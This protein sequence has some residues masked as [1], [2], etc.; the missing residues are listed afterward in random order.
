M[1]PSRFDAAESISADSIEENLRITEKKRNDF[2]KTLAPTSK[3]I[4]STA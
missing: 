4:E 1:L 3:R 2:R